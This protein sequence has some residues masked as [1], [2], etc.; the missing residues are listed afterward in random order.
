VQAFSSIAAPIQA[1][2]FYSEHAQG[3]FW[4]HDPAP[5]PSPSKELDDKS[6][7]AIPKYAQATQALEAYKKDLSDKKNLALMNPTYENVSAYMQA[8]KEMIAKAEHFSNLWQKVV[9]TTPELNYERVY[10]TAQYARHA[11]EDM[12]HQQ[13]EAR[14][15]ALSQ[16][17]GLF[18]FFKQSCQYC[19]TFAPIVRA[20]SEK[21]GWSVMAISLDGGSSTHFETVVPDN[22]IAAF[23]NIQAVPALVAF[24][25]VTQEMIPI[26]YALVSLDQLEQNLMTLIGGSP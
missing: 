25:A 26:S 2:P 7:I 19:Q 18:Y 13:R 1:R 23:L 4:Y 9:L 21:Y 8:Q 16:T 11:Q 24:N 17:H 10:P 20:F 15:K 14:I 12:E 22:G 5:L 6:N 3:W